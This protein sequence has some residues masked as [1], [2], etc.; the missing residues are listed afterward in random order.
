MCF[1]ETA[2]GFVTVSQCSELILWIAVSLLKLQ[3][4]VLD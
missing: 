4:V 1:D 3:V 2:T